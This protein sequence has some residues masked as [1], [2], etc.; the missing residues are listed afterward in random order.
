MHFQFSA[1]DGFIGKKSY[2]QV[3]EHLYLLLS[4]N[5][6]YPG[7]YELVISHCDFYFTFPND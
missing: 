1:Y 7:G 2:H 4:F 6:T 5:S 3:E